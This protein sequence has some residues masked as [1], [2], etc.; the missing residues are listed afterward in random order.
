MPLEVLFTIKVQRVGLVAHVIWWVGA[1]KDIVRG[2]INQK[3]SAVVSEVGQKSRNLHVELLRREKR[4][5]A[6]VVAFLVM[7]C[8]AQKMRYSKATRGA[9]VL[10]TVWILFDDI[11]SAFCSAVHDH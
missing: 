10:G 2:N 9:Y 6:L 11:R 4:E 3:D 1:V 8:Q 7:T 5:Y